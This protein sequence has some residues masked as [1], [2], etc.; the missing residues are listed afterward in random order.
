MKVKK[1]RYCPECSN[2]Q[3]HWKTGKSICCHCKIFNF[4]TG[5]GKRIMDINKIPTWC[6]LEEFNKVGGEG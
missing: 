2:R 6:P 5:N 1:I 4:K 3:K